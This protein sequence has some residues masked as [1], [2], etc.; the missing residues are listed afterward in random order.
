MRKSRKRKPTVTKNQLVSKSVE[1]IETRTPVDA[2]LI[3]YTYAEDVE[4]AVIGCLLLNSNMVMPILN[5]RGVNKDWFY[6]PANEAVFLTVQAMMSENIPA[7]LLSVC[8]RMKDKG[9]LDNAGG[10]IHLE[11]CVDL[12]P[13]AYGVESLIDKLHEKYLLRETVALCRTGLDACLAEK[14]PPMQ[15]MDT[16]IERSAQIRDSTHVGLS[17]TTLH[18]ESKQDFD[19]AA[20]GIVKGIPSFYTPLNDIIGA[21]YPTNQY[22]IAARPSDGKTTFAINEAIHKGLI[23]RRPVA[24]VS[25]EMSEKILREQMAGA[26]ADISSFAMRQG[27]FSPEHRTRFHKALDLLKDAPI[28][29][30]DKSMTIE[31]ICSWLIFMKARFKIEFAI[32]DYLQLV[33]SSPW[34]L[35]GMTTNDAVA[36]K[37][38]KLKQ[39]AKR[40]NVVSMVLSQLSRTGIRN[41]DSTPPPPTVE[42]LRDSGSIEQ[43]ADGIIFLYKKP[44]Q[45]YK[46]FISDKD[47]EMEIDVSKHRCGPLGICP[48]LFVRRRQK[49]ETMTQYEIRK[50]HEDIEGSTYFSDFFQTEEKTEAND[51]NTP[52]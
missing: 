25:Q 48:A 45:D 52:Y 6:V 24:I 1:A 44:E 26:I 31:E 38:A 34:M 47:W 23:L 2:S 11:R 20:K 30:N 29:I 28:Y 5:E 37:S 8:Q 22:V 32:T 13:T 27:H 33:L 39:T 4:K 10:A 49:W 36:A 41:R 51:F 14:Q 40:I 50:T 12:S 42:A 21:Y 35:N 18:E 19:D 9:H 43:D 15:V 17:V 3:T 7:D 16:L 46:Q